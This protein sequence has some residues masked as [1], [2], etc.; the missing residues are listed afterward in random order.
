[1]FCIAFLAYILTVFV[2]WNL[3]TGVIINVIEPDNEHIEEK[4]IMDQEKLKRIMSNP[5]RVG[6]KATCEQLKQ[7]RTMFAKANRIPYQT[8]KCQFE[9]ACS[10]TCLA[11]DSELEYLNSQINAMEGK[12]KYVK[13]P[14]AELDEVTKLFVEEKRWDDHCE[15]GSVPLM[16]GRI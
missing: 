13:Y 8:E 5:P 3:G 4:T 12:G 6:G 11:C 2:Q 15:C 7:L 16:R 14:Q 9:G 10:G 1:M